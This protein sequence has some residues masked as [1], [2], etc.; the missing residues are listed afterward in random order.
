MT[1]K[2]RRNYMTNPVPGFGTPERVR[3]LRRADGLTDYFVV[4]PLD[5][6]D[7]FNGTV[8]MH[9]SHIGSETA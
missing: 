6:N 4:R 7:G 2:C 9:V 5:R 8:A 1:I 3:V